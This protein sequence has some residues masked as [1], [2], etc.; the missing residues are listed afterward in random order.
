VGVAVTGMVEKFA[1]IRPER[2]RLSGEAGQPLF[3][4]VEIIPKKEHPFTIRRVQV[5]SGQFIKYEVEERTVDGQKRYVIRVENTR[6]EQGRYVDTLFVHTDSSFR[7]NIT[8]HVTG[9]IR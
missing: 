2:V 4:E 5:R 8:I 7:P 9:M 3:T 6:D 1:D